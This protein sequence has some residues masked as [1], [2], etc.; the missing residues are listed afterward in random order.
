MPRALRWRV[1]QPMR[2]RE[3]HDVLEPR[4]EQGVRARGL[5]REQPHRLGELLERGNVPDADVDALPGQLHLR[6][7]DRVQDHVH[8]QHRLRERLQVLLRSLR[9]D[10]RDRHLLHR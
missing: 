10:R 4:N 2:R 5:H 7:G 9:H 8:R 1:W 3:P 6:L